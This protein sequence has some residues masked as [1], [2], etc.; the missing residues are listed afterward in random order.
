[1]DRCRGFSGGSSEV[2]RPESSCSL[3]I[4]PSFVSL[5][6]EGD[7]VCQGPYVRWGRG[8]SA[9]L[10]F[11]SFISF[12][13]SQEWSQRFCASTGALGARLHSL[14]VLLPT[15]LALC[16]LGGRASLCGVPVKL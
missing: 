2:A 3:S 5:E 16:G 7:A 15:G 11:E 1:M 8:T 14:L 6:S 13:E 12:P 4:L 10:V 9:H